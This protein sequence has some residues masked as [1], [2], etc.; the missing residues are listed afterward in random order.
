MFFSVSV[1]F[2]KRFGEEILSTLADLAVLP[3]V[4]EELLRDANWRAELAPGISA[5]AVLKPISPPAGSLVM[6]AGG[7]LT[8]SQ[9]IL[10]LETELTLFG[11]SRPSDTQRVR[12]RELRI[13]Q[14]GIGQTPAFIAPVLDSFAPA[15]FHEM[16]DQDKLKAAAYEQLPSGVQ[17]SGDQEL[18]TDHILLRPV[19][20]EMLVQDKSVDPNPVPVPPVPEPQVRFE[21]LVPGG[22]V[23]DLL[24]Q[25]HG[26]VYEKKTE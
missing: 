16:A 9:Q 4:L 14:T 8:V 5:V 11:T 13:G 15:A 20:Y 22:I 24:S 26:P 7:R 25:P 23:G 3:R 21:Q 18:R 1:R 12:V 10:P 19:V 6:D 2:E 17:A